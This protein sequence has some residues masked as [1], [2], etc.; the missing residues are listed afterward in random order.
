MNPI[1]HALVG[2]CAAECVNGLETRE[3]AAIVIAGVAPD[4]DGFGLP[5]ELATRNT[6]SPM[7]WW[8]TAICSAKRTAAFSAGEYASDPS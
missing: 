1:T 8:S 5:V 4:F 7:L 6:D 3:R 2:W